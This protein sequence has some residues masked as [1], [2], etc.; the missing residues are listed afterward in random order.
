MASFISTHSVLLISRFDAFVKLFVFT[1]LA[2][3]ATVLTELFAH[4]VEFAGFTLFF[5]PSITATA[6]LAIAVDVVAATVATVNFGPVDF[7][8][9]LRCAILQHR[10]VGELPS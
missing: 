10:E 2:A 5:R 3:L 6:T 9:L 4:I 1:E 7:P 8:Y